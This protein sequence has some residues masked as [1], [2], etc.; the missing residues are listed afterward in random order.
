MKTVIYI[1]ERF[2]KLCANGDTALSF[3]QNEVVPSIHRGGSIAFDFMGVRNMNSSF[4][5]ALFANLV[6]Q[7]GVSVLEKV[8][9]RNCN[10]N[11]K[12]LI[13]A[14]LDFGY[15]KLPMPEVC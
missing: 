15:S 3:L 10:S 13:N 6:M 12:A 1:E 14:A 4:S 8:T 11:I 7:E 2:G 5:N 9:F